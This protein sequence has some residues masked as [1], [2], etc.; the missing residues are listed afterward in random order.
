MKFEVILQQTAREEAKYIARY[1]MLNAGAKITKKWEFQLSAAIDSLASMPRR[2][3][4]AREAQIIADI[5]LRQMIVGSYRMIFTIEH[6]NV[7]ILHIRHVSQ[8]RLGML[9]ED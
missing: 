8:D 7:H 6:K 4:F 5:E 3:P 2:C 9:E 1:L